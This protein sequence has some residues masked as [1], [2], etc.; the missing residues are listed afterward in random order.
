MTGA[1]GSTPIDMT[2]DRKPEPRAGWANN[3]H[4]V[5]FVTIHYPYHPFFGEELKV[6]KIIKGRI[7]HVKAPDGDVRGV[8][9]WMTDKDICAKIRESHDPYCSIDALK[10]LRDIILCYRA[11]P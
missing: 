1:D 3:A 6:V 9:V 11:D 7:F 5:S 4:K 8:P 2:L 10:G